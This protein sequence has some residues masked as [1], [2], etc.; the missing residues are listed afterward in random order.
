MTM[1]ADEFACALAAHA[2]DYG[3]RLTPDMI[4]R[5]TAYFQLLTAW[6]A[7]LHLV[8]PCTPA[9]FATRH[10]LESLVALRFIPTG[11]RFIDVGSGGGLPAI[12]CLIA[13]DDL[14]ATLFEAATKKAVFLRE[15]LSQ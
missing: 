12:P 7:R 14:R 6:N 4:A 11:A 8:A 1:V 10:V 9:E 15:A 5:L 2:L 3:A 13:R